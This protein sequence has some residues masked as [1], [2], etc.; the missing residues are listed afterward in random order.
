MIPL[1]PE[2]AEKRG[3]GL[4]QLV[5]RDVV[6]QSPRYAKV[7]EHRSLYYGTATA[8]MPLPW[9]GASA[10]HLPLIPEK[11]E[12]LV[13][14][15]N[16][17][18]WGVDPVVT[19]ERSPEEYEETQTDEVEQYM[20]FVVEKDI[21]DFYET[22]EGW[23][24][25]TT[26]D[27]MA[28]I[29]PYWSKEYRMVSEV[30]HM[31]TTIEATENADARF[32][33]PVELLVELYG[34]PSAINGLAE[35]LPMEEYEDGLVIGTRWVITFI[36]DREKYNGE[37]EFLPSS[38][39]DEVT[40][41]VRRMIVDRD[42]ALVD[43]IEYEDL[44][45]PFRSKNVQTADRVT[46]KYWL[47][48]D[49]VEE[50]WKSGEWDITEADMNV[51]R[52]QGRRQTTEGYLNPALQ[53]QK[54]GITGETGG[55]SSEKR[56]EL[57]K[58]FAPYNRN[59]VMVF[60]IH[61]RDDVDGLGMREEVIYHIPYALRKIVRA[62]YLDEVYAHGKRPFVIAKYL[63]ITDR[64]YAQGIGDQLAAINLEI[65]TIINYINNNQELINNPI[66]FYEA[67]AL[68]SDSEGIIELAPGTGIPV[69]SVQGLFFPQF[70]VTP[71][72]NMEM[73]S[74]LLMFA[75]RLTVSPLNAGSSQ[76]KNAPRTARG[77]MALL[78]EGH[79]KI[80]MLITRLQ[81]GPWME[82][83]EQLF[84][85]HEANCPDEKWYW[86]TR[87][88]TKSRARMTRQML[89][90]RYEFSF[91]GNTVNTNREV[92]RNIAQVRYNTVMTH[93]DYS[94]DPHVRRNA[95]VDFLKFW[96]DGTDVDRLVP[97]LPGEGAYSHP[98][99]SQQDE[100]KVMEL[101]GVVLPLP[102]DAHP[103]HLQ[104][105][106]QFQK[107]DQFAVLSQ[108]AV[109]IWANHRLMHQ[110]MLQAQMA[111]QQTPVGPGVGN[112][113][114]QGMTQQGGGNEDSNVLGGGN[115]R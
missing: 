46:Q 23:M 25:D 76:M 29:K 28:Y 108:A 7:R 18:F 57:P 99:M 80:D 30:H 24:R 98:L 88:D 38:K 74:S 100:N 105:M 102:G 6:D 48:V 35:A 95:M 5:E 106:D 109:G 45:M 39:I 26:L 1:D 34:P 42:C 20:N 4:V 40:L 77:T 66:F 64:V 49:E 51:L 15:L 73:L 113:V 86:V 84:G 78:G 2:F 92:L 71:L 54:D 50:K 63:P 11:V 13:P 83:M 16:S 31:T 43:S 27:G 19:V 37:V 12:T 32:K 97:A 111:N 107:T 52:N 10:I 93:P 59:K 65:N 79:V 69:L 47:T 14:M 90:G 91:K 55:E 53:D 68:N 56:L 67:T 115:M 70:P 81:R 3:I 87:G 114:P 72:S 110:Q 89:R 22:F 33:D 96:G 41:R 44:I 60:L 58:G 103:E 82:L 17:A 36:E 101:G 21:P 8:N 9:K 112:N 85:L 104:V 62:D 61:L 75:D 94:T